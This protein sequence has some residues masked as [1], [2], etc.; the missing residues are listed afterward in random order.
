MKWWENELAL[1]FTYE[2]NFPGAGVAIYAG[3]SWQVVRKF[4]LAGGKLLTWL[5]SN[6]GLLLLSGRAGFHG[7]LLQLS[8]L[9]R[10]NPAVLRQRVLENI[11][12][13]DDQPVLV[14]GSDGAI[15]LCWQYR[16]RLNL[17]EIHSE[18][19]N[20]YK[21][22]ESDIFYPVELITTGG[23]DCFAGQIALKMIHGIEL[24]FPFVIPVEALEMMAVRHTRLKTVQ[25]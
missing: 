3:G 14:S 25:V 22:M 15:K 13:W 24:D 21:H 2:D 7:G 23:Q 5:L 18:T 16:R 9:L 10:E 8:L 4:Q 17:A 20:L 12:G 19:L 6:Q 1:I 11:V